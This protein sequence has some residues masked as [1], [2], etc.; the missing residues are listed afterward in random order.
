MMTEK[1]TTKMTMMIATQWDYSL[2]LVLK[3]DFETRTSRDVNM[4]QYVAGESSCWS[5]QI[6]MMTMM[7][8]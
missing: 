4:L 8:L 7:M 6:M 5:N 3:D 1:V 2:P